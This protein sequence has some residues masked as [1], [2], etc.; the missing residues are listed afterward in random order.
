MQNIILQ[1]R[2]I[3]KI[4]KLKTKYFLVLAFIVYLLYNLCIKVYSFAKK[5]DVEGAKYDN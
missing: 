1:K 4:K 2:I 3:V 5:Y